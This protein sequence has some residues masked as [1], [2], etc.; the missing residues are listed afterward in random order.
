MPGAPGHP[1]IAVTASLSGQ[2]KAHWA[3][4]LLT[5][6]GRVTPGTA[7]GI[8]L[9]APGE[10]PVVSYPRQPDCPACGDRP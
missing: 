2:L 1:V 8:N 7:W 6:T 4:A 9:M 5:G 3:I 10:P